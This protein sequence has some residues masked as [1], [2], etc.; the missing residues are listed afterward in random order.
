MVNYLVD[1]SFVDG[2][3]F[4]GAWTVSAASQVLANLSLGR[5]GVLL[6]NG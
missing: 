1:K 5:E 6:V 4:G 3:S 2:G